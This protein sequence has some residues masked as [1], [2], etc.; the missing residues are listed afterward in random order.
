MQK[1]AK[2]WQEAAIYPGG[3]GGFGGIA[4]SS[5]GDT[6]G[7]PPITWE[8]SGGIPPPLPRET[9]ENPPNP[10]FP[11]G[12]C[13]QAAQ[14]AIFPPDSILADFYDL[15]VTVV[16]GA[17]C[18]IIGAILPVCAS[19]MARDVWLPWAG[20]SLHCN[21]YAM[22]AGKP[23]DRKSS[24]IDL[25]E[26]LA[27]KCL[28]PEAFLPKTFSPETLLDEYDINA[29]GRPDKIWICDDANATLADWQSS[30]TGTR[31]ATRFLELYDCKALSESYRRNRKDKQLG[32]QRRYIPF[33]STSIVFGATFN[34]CTFRNQ[35]TRAGMQ[36][37]FLY[38]VAEGHGRMILY[39]QLDSA[40]FDNLVTEFS[41][42]RRLAGPFSLSSAARKLFDNFQRENRVRLNDSDPLDEP[43]LSRLSSSP[44]QM[45]KVAMIFEACRS[46]RAASG[47]LVIQETTLR[48][49]IDHVNEC[50]EAA[51]RLDSIARRIYIANDAEVLLAR[52][53]FDFRVCA[54][55]GSI[56]LSRTELTSKYADHGRRG[57]GL[58][59][60][61]L[62]T[63]LIPYLISR[64][65]AK[66]LPKAGKLE[67]YAFRV[68][69]P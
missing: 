36:R 19:L 20:T 5:E 48:F 69:K 4:R 50:L 55:N 32:A 24:T 57:R 15:A 38:Y 49:A 63:S 11:P 29:G 67:R 47:S 1:R 26:M 25:P 10:P 54:K 7:I 65:D 52:I 62:Y 53:R 3:I 34:I 16:E 28:S 66:A 14:K 37:R 30:V 60:Q 9:G 40:E 59:V 6:G 2:N 44:S 43:L 42:L 8:E 31:N 18:Y 21:L 33:T 68:E 51:A 58:N 23:G 35:A 27:R 45:L 13:T 12:Y 46:V 56:I 41:L 17:D 61:E 64:G 39:P 22:L